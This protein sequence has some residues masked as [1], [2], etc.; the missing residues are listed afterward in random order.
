M[1]QGIIEH[2]R[3]FLPVTETTPVVTL[4]EGDTPLIPAPRLA[5]AI[6][7][8]SLRSARMICCLV[9]M[10]RKLPGSLSQF[11]GR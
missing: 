3:E 9:E 11:R 8:K 6:A 2:Y 7:P 4:C 5:A 1:R 10:T